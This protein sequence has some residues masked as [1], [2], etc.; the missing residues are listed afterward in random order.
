[1]T[2]G[3]PSGTVTL[4]FTDIEGSTRLLQ[5]LGR[6]AYVRALSQHRRLLREVFRRHG[7][8]EVEMQGDSF[9]FAFALARNGVAA[10]AEGQQA[11][12][13][14]DWESK[15]IRV[16]IG[17]HTGEPVVNEDLYAGLDVH[18]AARVMS[19]GHGGQVIISESTRRLLDSSFGLRDLGEHRLKDLALPMR[20]YQLGE[21][22]FP[23]LKTLDATNLPV[24]AGPLLGR[25]QELQEL[26]AL[27][28]DGSRLVTVTGPGGT[29]KTRLALQVAAELVGS[30]ADGVFWVPLASVKDP[31]LVVPTIAQTVD[32]RGG[33]TEHLRAKQMMLLLDNAEHLLSAAPALAELLVTS[34][35]VRLLV[36]SRAPLHLSAEREYPLEPLP[37]TDAVTLFVERGRAVGRELAPSDTIERICRRLDGLPLA[38]ELAAA[39]TKL[40]DPAT[41]LGRL[42]QALPLLTGGARDAPERQR[43]LRATIDWSYDL[44]DEN[45]KRLFARLSIFTGTF[46]LEAAEE[47]CSADLETVAALV[48]LSLLKAMGDTR[49]LMLETIREYGLARIE[50]HREGPELYRRHCDYYLGMAVAA[51]PELKDTNPRPTLDRLAGERPNLRAALAHCASADPERALRLAVDLFEFFNARAPFEAWRVLESLYREDVEPQLR[52]SALRVLTFFAFDNEDIAEAQRRAE[53]WLALAHTLGDAQSIS[54]ALSKLAIIARRAGDAENAERLEDRALEVARDL[55]DPSVRG[56]LLWGRARAEKDFGDADRAVG[57]FGESL[58]AYASA[59]NERGVAFAQNG[60]GISHCH[61]GEWEQARDPLA[62]ALRVIHDAGHVKFVAISLDHLAAV[63]A[64]T[65]NAALAARLLGAG[66]SA[67]KSIGVP[68]EHAYRL[69]YVEHALA[70]ARSTL[71]DS[72]YELERERGASMELDDAVREALSSG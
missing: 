68:L 50:E 13:E 5:E 62:Q 24:A 30:F 70:I 63:A 19:A 71:G 21:G 69:P 39:R 40:I 15:S 7:G 61:L 55:A 10:A 66:D 11:L 56:Y 32:A 51:L 48:D 58:A 14:H 41:L 53:E 1:M 4:V 23:P 47:I 2:R 33:L 29:G 16:R 28:R 60:I 37:P 3:L 8:V 57:L 22:D 67:W 64:A 18:R 42:E 25:R 36:T 35:K 34:P 45:A 12:A 59:N 44:L 6:D 46:S 17:I 38:I 26:I 27:L 54:M 65:G 72:A 9:F 31:E 49:F 43:T 20:L 52:L